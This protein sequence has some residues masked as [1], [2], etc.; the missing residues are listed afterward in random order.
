MSLSRSLVTGSVTVAVNESAWTG[1]PS[2]EN[3]VGGWQ[4]HL[5]STLLSSLQQLCVGFGISRLLSPGGCWLRCEMSDLMGRV[6]PNSNRWKTRCREEDNGRCQKVI[7]WCGMSHKLQ[8]RI[9]GLFQTGLQSGC[10]GL[11]WGDSLQEPRT[12]MIHP[13]FF[14]LIRGYCRTEG[15][16]WTFDL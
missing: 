16:G 6:G 10:Q 8:G 5:P 1:S 13:S 12:G 2:A 4:N 15:K 14:A 11:I 9:A 3:K 7:G